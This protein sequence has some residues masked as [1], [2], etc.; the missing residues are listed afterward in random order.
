MGVDAA[1]NSERRPRHIAIIMDGNG[2]WARR[3]LMPRMA[4]H[5]AGV[6]SV[7][8][9]VRACGQQGVEVL[10]LFAFSS[11]NWRRPREEVGALMELFI[12]A[13]QREA[14]ELDRNNVRLHIVGERSALPERLQQQITVA[15]ETTAGNTGLTLLIAANYG[16]RWD[17]AEAARRLARQVEAGTLSVDAVDESLLAG[18]MALNQWPDPDLFI[19]TGGERR[20]SNFLIWQ[21]AYAE[22]YFTDTLWP[23]F[24][25]QALGQAIEWFGG[26]Q[27]RFG[28]TGEQVETDNHGS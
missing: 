1:A 15:E 19:R 9:V 3:R 12:S 24:D 27:R 2:R 14:R 4:G 21:L 10:T 28:R 26:R 17:I 11:E 20:I 23:D 16:G 22:L 13:L 5:R 7:R 6:G 8:S 18:Q 25:G